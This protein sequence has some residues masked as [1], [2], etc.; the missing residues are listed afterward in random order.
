M[1]ASALHKG[2][3]FAIAAD[4]IVPP[5]DPLY[6]REFLVVVVICPDKKLW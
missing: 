5:W 6:A 4:K 3:G 2:S 1:P